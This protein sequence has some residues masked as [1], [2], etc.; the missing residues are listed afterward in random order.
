MS[1]ISNDDGR[2]DYGHKAMEKVHIDFDQ[3]S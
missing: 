1:Q 3:E 2:A